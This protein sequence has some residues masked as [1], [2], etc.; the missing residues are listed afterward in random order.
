[1]PHDIFGNLI[2]GEDVLAMLESIASQ[3]RLDAHQVGLA[4]ILRFRQNHQLLHAAL[5]YAGAIETSSDILIAEALNVLV[6]PEL[7]VSIRVAAA[8]ALGHLISQRPPA[9]DSDFDLDKVLEAMAHV[10]ARSESRMLKKALFQALG[11]A[12]RR[13]SRN[14]PQS[15]LQMKKAGA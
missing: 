12:R 3:N 8:G 1:M 9:M 15:L 13:K 2:H 14:H 4:R 10:L 6:A 5:E 7:P 11:L